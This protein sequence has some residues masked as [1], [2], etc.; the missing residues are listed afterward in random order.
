MSDKSNIEWTDATWNPV[1]GCTK[2]SPGCKNCYAET[3]AERFRGV[4]GHPYEQ[5]FDLRLIPEK[6]DEP[7]HWRKPRR[8]FVNSMSDLFQDGVDD[9]F[10]SLV[11]ATMYCSPQHTF[12][13]LTKRP[14]RMLNYL[15]EM[16]SDPDGYCFAW[17]HEEFGSL[18]CGPQVWPLPN[19]WLGVSVESQQYA[20]ERIPLL[21]QTPAAVRFIS[22]EPALGPID[23]SDFLKSHG[24]IGPKKIPHARNEHCKIAGCK[25]FEPLDW[26]IVGG[27]SGPCSRPFN[28]QWARDVV[29][30][31]QLAGVSVFVKQLGAKPFLHFESSH[32][33]ERPGFKLHIEQM[34]VDR[35]F[36]LKDRKGGDMSEWE[37][38][39]RVREFPAVNA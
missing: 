15:K 32:H 13:I 9:Q 22:Y 33:E 2:V 30:Q 12:Q 20:D 34:Q 19:V 24:V 27:E 25:H 35:T 16:S 21:Q 4:A 18:K 8:I 28:I 11:F 7:L 1:R 37:E 14:E 38:A 10:I 17:A 26:V 23:I 36:Q 39:L 29:Q 3:F 31:C 5:G 6:L